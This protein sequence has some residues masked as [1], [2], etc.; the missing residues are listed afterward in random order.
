MTNVI[1]SFLFIWGLILTI[2]I[3]V[4]LTI[5]IMGRLHENSQDAGAIGILV[6]VSALLIG[7]VVFG[8]IVESVSCIFV[9][10]SMDKRFL[11]R[12]LIDSPRL[13]IESYNTIDQCSSEPL[14]M[15]E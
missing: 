13:S 6:G 2:G 7:T 9:F 14:Q 3:P 11:K 10:F 15:G 12:K 1:C 4:I 5:L 8:I